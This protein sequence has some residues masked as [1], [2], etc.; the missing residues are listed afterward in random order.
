MHHL[1]QKL[2]NQLIHTEVCNSGSMHMVSLHQTEIQLVLNSCSPARDDVFLLYPLLTQGD[3]NSYPIVQ[4]LTGIQDCKQSVQ[5]WW[6]DWSV[7]RAR[8]V[9]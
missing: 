6:M 1:T 4:G 5:G 8:H 3:P 9:P 7:P 2:A